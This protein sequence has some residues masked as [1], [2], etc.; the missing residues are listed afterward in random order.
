VL[1]PR[2]GYWNERGLAVAARIRSVAERV[3]RKPVH[4]AL[5]ALLSFEEVSAV[6]VGVS[7]LEQLRDLDGV[8]PGALDRLMVRDVLGGGAT[9]TQTT[10]V[11]SVIDAVQD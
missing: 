9:A 2:A 7:S 4:V 6:L 3:G 11:T 10:E 1:H 8:K 5:E